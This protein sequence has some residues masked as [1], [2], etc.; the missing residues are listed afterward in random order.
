MASHAEETLQDRLQALTLQ[1]L[2]SARRRSLTGISRRLLALAAVVE[3][4]SDE[5]SLSCPERDFLS[6]E[7]AAVASDLGQIVGDAGDA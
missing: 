1:A 6:D 5:A 3:A 7:I 2:G 4:T